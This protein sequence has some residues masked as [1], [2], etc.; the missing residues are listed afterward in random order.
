MGHNTQ[1]KDIVEYCKSMVNTE[2]YGE[3]KT[4]EGE[5][6]VK[7]RKISYYD[8]KE[9]PLN[10]HVTSPSLGNLLKLLYHVL[11]HA[12]A[13]R[14]RKYDEDIR[15]CLYSIAQ[16]RKKRSENGRGCNKRLR[17]EFA[18]FLKRFLERRTFPCIENVSENYWGSRQ[19]LRAGKVI[20]DHIDIQNGALDPIYGVLLCPSAGLRHSGDEKTKSSLDSY[21]I[22]DN[23]W[24]NY[25]ELTKSYHAIMYD[26]FRYLKEYHNEGPGPDY[27]A[28]HALLYWE[29][30]S[31]QTTSLLFWKRTID[32][33]AEENIFVEKKI[34]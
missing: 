29:P 16:L 13:S 21:Q 12:E 26:S 34:V 1:Q 8:T 30:V 28:S 27:L 23:Y 7:R 17:N 6:Q 11:V 15:Q 5:K 22:V 2:F 33:I 32:R 31:E 25:S 10:E 9:Y 19:Q 20:A 4:E 3:E 18:V 24:W 14:I